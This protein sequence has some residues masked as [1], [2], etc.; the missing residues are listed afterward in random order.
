MRT[1]RRASCGRWPRAAED[2]HDVPRPRAGARPQRSSSERA[3]DAVVL[4]NIMPDLHGARS[5]SGPWAARGAGGAGPVVLMTPPTV[6]S[7]IEAMKL[8]ALDYLQKPFEI[9]ELLVVVRRA[10]ELQ[11]CAASTATC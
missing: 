2:G 10:V 11:R 5:H 3:F 7:A 1:T 9:D 8:G 4:D 6:E